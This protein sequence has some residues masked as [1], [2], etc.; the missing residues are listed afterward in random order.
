MGIH[1]IDQPKDK[2]ITL[3]D[4]TKMILKWEP[5]FANR[6]MDMYNRAQRFL[7]AQ[8]LYRSEDYIPV[9]EGKLIQSGRLYTRIG[10]GL[11]MWRAGNYGNVSGAYAR[12]VYYG[13]RAPGRQGPKVTKAFLW[14]HKMKRISGKQL[15]NE[16]KRIAGGGLG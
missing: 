4:G 2:V 16:T 12:P 9:R 10:S 3:R 11:V 6:R 1:Y 7:D 5:N 8:V 13:R 14:F 15:V